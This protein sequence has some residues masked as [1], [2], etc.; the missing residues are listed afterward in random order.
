MFSR[1]GIPNRD[2]DQD[3]PFDFINGAP[4][5]F[6]TVFEALLHNSSRRRAKALATARPIMPQ[7]HLNFTNF[8]TNSARHVAL[9]TR[10]VGYLRE[11]PTFPHG[12]GTLVPSPAEGPGPERGT[13]STCKQTPRLRSGHASIPARSGPLLGGRS[14]PLSR[15]GIPARDSGN[16]V[17]SSSTH[18]PG[19]AGIVKK[20]SCRIRFKDFPNE[21][22]RNSH[23]RLRV[24][25][26]G[27]RRKVRHL[28][29]YN[30]PQKL[31]QW[32]R[33]ICCLK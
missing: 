23:S 28:K 31:D 1:A 26:F 22:L 24:A 15:L 6:D 11:E 14:A 17:F 8:P 20:R 9:N 33:W 2:S 18:P 29:Y 4:A 13:L 21:Y 25:R 5:R 32:L 3:F 19:L 27:G 7:L 12:F 30:T 16:P 10:K